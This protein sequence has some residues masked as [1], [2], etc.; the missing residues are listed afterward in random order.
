[1]SLDQLQKEFDALDHTLGGRAQVPPNCFLLMKGEYVS[2]D[3]R[4]QLTVQFPVLPEYSN[5]VGQMQGGFITA[6]IDNTI[7]PLS[8]LAARA[9]CTTLDFFTQYLRSVEAGDVHT[10]TARLTSRSPQT[11]TFA[12]EALNGK[13]KAVAIASATMMILKPRAIPGI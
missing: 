12:A 13:G 3:S 10:V 2:Y 5:P 4:S 11:V 6:A 1:M 7:G 9:P 8:Y